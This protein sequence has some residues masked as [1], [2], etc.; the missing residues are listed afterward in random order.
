MNLPAASRKNE[1]DED[2]EEE[3]TQPNSTALCIFSF[4][5]PRQLGA[6]ASEGSLG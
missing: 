2:E 5:F 4:R 1:E 3:A 6:L